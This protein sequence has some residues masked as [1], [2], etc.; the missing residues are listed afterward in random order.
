MH[1]EGISIL[2]AILRY[3]TKQEL[4]IAVATTNPLQF[5]VQLSEVFLSWTTVLD[6]DASRFF[7]HLNDVGV[8]FWAG[9]ADGPIRDDALLSWTGIK[10]ACAMTRYIGVRRCGEELAVLVDLDCLVEV[11]VLGNLN[12]KVDKAVVKALAEYSMQKLWPTSET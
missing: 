10:N 8:E 11:N 5:L 1:V 3:S 9:L 12:H 7:K 2:L 4:I 6:I